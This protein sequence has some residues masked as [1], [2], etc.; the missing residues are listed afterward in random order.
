MIEADQHVTCREADMLHE[1][2]VVMKLRNRWIPLYL[3]HAQT[4]TPVIWCKKNLVLKNGYVF[5]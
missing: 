2:L 5:F 4:M 1:H 3:T